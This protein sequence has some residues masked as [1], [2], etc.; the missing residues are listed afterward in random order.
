MAAIDPCAHDV[1]RPRHRGRPYLARADPRAWR[2]RTS[3]RSSARAPSCAP[4]CATAAGLST[5]SSIA[6]QLQELPAA[7]AELRHVLAASR[8][9]DPGTARRRSSTSSRR[10]R[11][12][13]RGVPRAGWWFAPGRSVCGHHRAADPRA[14]L[15]DPDI[16]T[17]SPTPIRDTPTATC[18]S[19]CARCSVSNWLSLGRKAL[20]ARPPP[21]EM[22]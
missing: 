14:E 3:C 10:R 8:S 18:W 5:G 16:W 1:P 6:T 2:G 11:T 13:P 9:A 4:A 15:A 21:H 17:S 22:H 20:A 19:A 12:G 7:A